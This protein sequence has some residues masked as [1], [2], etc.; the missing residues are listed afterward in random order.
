VLT[1]AELMAAHRLELPYG[2]DPTHLRA[3]GSLPG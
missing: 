2:F 3:I 1:D